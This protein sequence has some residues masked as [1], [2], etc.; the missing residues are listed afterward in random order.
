[1]MAALCVVACSDGFE[2]GEKTSDVSSK[3]GVAPHPTTVDLAIEGF[4]TT[5]FTEA[6]KAPAVLRESCEAWY[7]LAARRYGREV[8]V[9]LDCGVAHDLEPRSEYA[10]LVSVPTAK[11]RV[12]VRG[13]TPRLQEG[14]RVVGVH[15]VRT[16]AFENWRKNCEAAVDRKQ[17]E[18]GPRF[19]AGFCDAPS[20]GAPDDAISHFVSKLVYWVAPE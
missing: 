3:P 17:K 16:T 9:A 11:V 19:L 13:G 5:H 6:H 12:K 4:A 20:R 1:M 7:E 8:V 2:E 10:M 18:L 15:R 14:E